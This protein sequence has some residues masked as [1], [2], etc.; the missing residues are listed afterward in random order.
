M[1]IL[2]S[3]RTSTCSLLSKQLCMG[4]MPV[5]RLFCT[6]SWSSR[7]LPPTLCCMLVVQASSGVAE[8]VEL[9]TK[10]AGDIMN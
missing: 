3:S 1:K 4:P 5:Q 10:A 9:C 8:N 7:A 2:W 6:L